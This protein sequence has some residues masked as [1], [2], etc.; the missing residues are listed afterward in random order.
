MKH[1]YKLFYI[2][3]MMGIAVS[4]FGGWSE[5]ILIEGLNPGFNGYCPNISTNENTSFFVSDRIDSVYGGIRVACF[6]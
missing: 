5:P 3:I 2:M 4:A 1:F 6:Y